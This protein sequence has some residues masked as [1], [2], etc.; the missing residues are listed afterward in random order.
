MPD[1]ST[2]A[3]CGHRFKSVSAYQKHRVA[4]SCRTV[5]QMLAVGM[6]RN[7]NGLWVAREWREFRKTSQASIGYRSN[8]DHWPTLR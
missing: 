7:K 5:A 2:C 1:K 6:V 8:F 4:L 3:A